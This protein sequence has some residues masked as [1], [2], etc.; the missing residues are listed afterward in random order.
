[1]IKT[2]GNCIVIKSN[3]THMQMPHDQQLYGDLLKCHW[4]IM[5][6]YM[7]IIVFSFKHI[8]LSHSSGNECRALQKKKKTNKNTQINQSINKRIKK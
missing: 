6:W 5:S 2:F 3:P 8:V 4:N 7:S 1:M